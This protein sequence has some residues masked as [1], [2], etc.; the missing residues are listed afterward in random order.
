MGRKL[1]ELPSSPSL[2]VAAPSGSFFPPSKFLLGNKAQGKRA[3]SW[4]SLWTTF[5]AKSQAQTP[6]FY[7][8]GEPTRT[9]V[10][11]GSEETNSACGE[12]G[13]ESSGLGGGAELLHPSPS[14]PEMQ[15]SEPPRLSTGA[16]LPAG[17]SQ[18]GCRALGEGGHQAPDLINQPALLLTLLH[19]LY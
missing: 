14:L 12:E 6:A 15:L 2:R 7:L 13:R 17:G 19:F 11:G 1:A 18:K 3:T 5:F 10:P 4:V 8:Q 16:A 9:A